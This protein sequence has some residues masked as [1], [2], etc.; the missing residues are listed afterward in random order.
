MSVLY[1][2]GSAYLNVNG[3]MATALQ[4]GGVSLPYHDS[5]TKPVAQ[6]PSHQMQETV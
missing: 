2:R 1:F 6:F 4:S 3:V 5:T